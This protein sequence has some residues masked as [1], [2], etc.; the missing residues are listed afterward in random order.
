MKAGA[1]IRKW[2]RIV[3]AAACLLATPLA[4]DEIL[5]NSDFSKD[6]E[7]WSGDFSNDPSEDNP[8]DPHSTGQITLNLRDRRPVRIF[9]AFNADTE[10]FVCNVNFTLSA[11]GA[12]TA[13][14]KV[15]DVA[16]DVSVNEISS[17]SYDP[18]T[19]VV[20]LYK[21][22]NYATYMTSFRSPVIIMADP[23]DARVLLFPLGNPSANSYSSNDPSSG[24]APFTPPNDPAGTSFTVHATVRSHRSYRLYLAF[25]PGTGSVTVTRISL[26]PDTP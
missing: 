26:Q 9:Q 4:A 7:N 16:S 19:G 25:P 24:T 22:K 14:A 1:Q 15:S 21:N 10:N 3:L 11:G 17:N 18:S 8:L 13:Y 2:S 5:L 23:D 12:Y 6:T 20:T